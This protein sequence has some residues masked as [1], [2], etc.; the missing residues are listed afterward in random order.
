MKKLL[1]AFIAACLLAFTVQAQAPPILWQHTYGGTYADIGYTIAHTR[2]GGYIMGGTSQSVN[3]DVA[4]HH[5]DSTIINT[6]LVKTDQNGAIIWQRSYFGKISYYKSSKSVIQSADGGYVMVGS[7]NS[8]AGGLT[9]YHGSADYWVAKL[10]SLGAIVWQRS[11]GGRYDDIATSV[12]ETPNGGYIVAGSSSSNDGDVSGHHGDSSTTDYWVVK[13]DTVGRIVWQQS[14]GGTQSEIGTAIVQSTDG[15]CV[16]TGSTTSHDG[17][18][19]RNSY[20]SVFA[21]YWL[22]KLDS[23]GTI[24]W[25]HCYGGSNFDYAYSMVKTLDGGYAVVG[26]SSSHNGLVTVNHGSGD[27]WLIRLD[28]IG[29]LIWQHSYGGSGAD[30]AYGLVQ[31]S[32]GGFAIAGFT[33]SS[34]SDVTGYHG[35]L[36]YWVVKTSSTGAL[37]WQKTL[38]GSS[39]DEAYSIT[40]DSYGG[41]VVLGMAQSTNGDVTGNH[42]NRDYWAVD[43]RPLCH[44]DTTAAASTICAGASYL[45]HTASGTYIDTLVNMGGCDSFRTLHLTVNNAF[46][47]APLLIPS[48]RAAATPFT[49][50][51]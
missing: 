18:V 34:D 33:Y 45:G 46:Y 22:V 25:Q 32:D 5:G 4:G 39:L 42:G 17:D 35:G 1:L 38:G 3:G 14:L 19:T 7:A 6:W 9:G 44:A 50:K 15:G 41:Y 16:I 8:N 12:I 37:V 36:D 10:D 11:L 27:Y 47:P 43:L 48:A 23:I 40:A 31:S 20:D 51:A 28:S 26:I 21:D 2:D 49:V 30:Y 24:V 29:S 13:L